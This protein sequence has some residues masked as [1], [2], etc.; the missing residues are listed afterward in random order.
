M[1]QNIYDTND[2]FEFEKINISKPISLSAGVFVLKFTIG[3]TPLYVNPPKCTMKLS[4]KTQKRTHCDFIFSQENDQ[5]IR[6]IENLEKIAQDKIYENRNQWFENELEKEDIENYFTSS[7]KIYKSGKYYIL[8]TNL[9]NQ[10][11]KQNFKIY[12]ENE[13]EMQ[14]DAITESMQIMCVLEIQGIKCSS[15]NF[16]IDIVLKQMMV[17][18]PVDLFEKCIL[19]KKIENSQPLVIMKHEEKPSTNDNVLEK[20]R[21]VETEVEEREPT[22]ENKITLEEMEEKNEDLPTEIFEEVVSS[23]KNDLCEVDFDIDEMDKNDTIV[24]KKRNEMYY[25][26]YMEARRKAKIARDLALSAYLEARRIKNT[27]MLDDIL[28]TSDD[29]SD[30]EELEQINN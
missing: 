19:K 27:Y 8:R 11:Q 6:W 1:Q 16:Q 7:L 22:I 25:E 2:D 15:S 10:Q 17:L 4:S 13:N 14:F 3:N 18:Q 5:F 24:I 12:D 28:D 23:D 20:E 30:I 21:E 26:M 29:E 9:P